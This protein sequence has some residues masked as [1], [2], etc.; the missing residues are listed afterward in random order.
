MAT[1][2]RDYFGNCKTRISAIARVCYLGRRHWKE[3]HQEHVR[4][5]EAKLLEQESELKA[6]EA[7]ARLLLAE[8]EQADERV[9]VLEQRL[10]EL[11]RQPIRL[12]DDPPAAGQQYGASLMAL[13]VNLA[14][15]IGQRKSV[16]AM[17][18]FFSWLKIKQELPTYQ[19]VRT[20]MQRLGLNRLRQAARKDDWIW[21]V[22]QSTQIGQ[23]SC[24]TILG[25]EQSKLP[26]EGT[27]LKL[28]DMTTLEVHP[29]KNWNR[30]NVLK[31]YQRVAKKY[32]LPE[33]VIT[34]G[35]VELRE[36]VERLEI[37]GE[38]PRSIRDMKHFLANRFEELMHQDER[39]QAFI[40]EMGQ[41]RS[42]MQQTEL[43]HL[44]PPVMRQKSR[45]MNLAPILAWSSMALWQL[46]HPASDGRKGLAEHRV[47]DKLGWLKQYKGDVQ[48]W[49]QIQAVISATLT[50]MNQNGLKHGAA[51]ELK[52]ELQHLPQ[53]Q[54][55]CELIAQILEFVQQH[56]R[57]LKPDERLPMSSEILE[58]SFARFKT[59]EQFHA[60]SGF[61]QVL[62]AFPC[63]LKRTTKSEIVRAFA[64]TKVKDTKAWMEERMPK[65]HD[66]R[67]QS[68]YREYHRAIKLAKTNYRA[69]PLAATG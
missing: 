24:L 28:E 29:A 62:L 35:A 52:R 60:R 45:F 53:N 54:A 5:L 12:P 61:T 8:R 66:G 16:R 20:W 10:A 63:L 30:E 58:S 56:E 17:K 64:K 25:I 39:Y 47:A 6:A 22:D 49:N 31:I 33:A 14:R 13:S 50:F 15:E 69:T 1:S 11:K 48:R 65:T 59:F 23:D 46:D 51:R 3:K 7:R 34:D 55:S 36:P 4:Q 32:G 2:W 37:E 57:K 43:S 26:P 19:A 21:L 44:A 38:K 42:S 41:S 9:A 67:R 40:E 27:P 18:T 68:A